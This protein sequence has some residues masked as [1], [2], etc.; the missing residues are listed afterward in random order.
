MRKKPILSATLVASFLGCSVAIAQEP[1]PGV[2]DP[3]TPAPEEPAT[4]SPGEQHVIQKLAA[5]FEDFAGDD[6]AALIEALRTGSDLSYEVQKEIEV[7]VQARDE[8][9]NE[10]LFEVDAEGNP[11]STPV[12]TTEIQTI[13]ET[14][15]VENTVG[16][17]GFGNAKITMLLAQEK[18]RQD[19]IEGSLESIS[20]AL[21][22][23]EDGILQMRADGAGWGEISKEVLGTNL[24]SLVGKGAGKRPEADP[25]T[26]DGSVAAARP[27]RQPKEKAAPSKATRPGKAASLPKPAKRER[28]GRPVKAERPTKAVKFERPA[29]LERPTRPEKPSRP[30]K[31]ARP[32]RPERPEKPAKPERPNR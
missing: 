28:T 31:P 12:M 11:T 7:E 25:E 10:L 32:E 14:I 24:G 16:P 15:V 18:L 27:T 9:T 2:E 6:S 26:G 13:T 5:S 20:G 3:G 4:L 29:K 30:E 1:E 22:G 23:S 8:N 19:G 17:M 21:F